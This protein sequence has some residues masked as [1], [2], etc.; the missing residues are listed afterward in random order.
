MEADQVLETYVKNMGSELGTLFHALSHELTWVHWRWNQYRILFGEKPSRIELLNASAPFF[1]RVI[2]D[3]LF[4]ETLLG[5]SRLIDPSESGVGKSNLTV[6]ALPPLC[7]PKI[8]GQIRTL[9]QEAAKAGKFTKDWR[10]R[11]IAHRD[12][13]LALDRPAKILEPATREKVEVSLSALRD[14]LN[15]I[16]HEYCKGTTTYYDSP[17]P[18][19]ARTLLHILR[20]GLLREKDRQECWNRGER[21]ADDIKPLEPI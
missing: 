3:A 20:D 16:E 8:Q 17:N 10:N 9:V 12:L 11:H 2:Q 15:A 13:D 19:D 21:H 4:E 18:W 1:F 14:V 5:I 7:Q 6:Q